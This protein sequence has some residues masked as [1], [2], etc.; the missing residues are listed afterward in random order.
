MISALPRQL[1][2]KCESDAADLFAS[3]PGIGRTSAHR[4]QDEIGIHTLEELEMAA[5][6]GRLEHLG[7]GQKRLVG[8]RDA[9][10][11]RLGRL[12]RILFSG[13]LVVAGKELSRDT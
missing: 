5:H 1:G 12:G 3:V 11:G 13:W 2:R 10:A 7:I 8:I 6:D 4:I 9:L